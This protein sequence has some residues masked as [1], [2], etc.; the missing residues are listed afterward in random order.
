MQINILN[1]VFEID[2]NSSPDV[3]A[4]LIEVIATR[5]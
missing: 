5:F 3:S 2:P 4:L 1:E